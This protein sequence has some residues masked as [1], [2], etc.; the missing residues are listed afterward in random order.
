MQS[1]KKDLISGPVGVT[2]ID[3]IAK[4]NFFTVTRSYFLNVVEK[5]TSFT[6]SATPNLK[7]NDD[8]SKTLFKIY[9]CTNK[10]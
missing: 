1:D 8:A 6:L 9:L 10:L 7:I 3:V 4:N 5:I 2:K